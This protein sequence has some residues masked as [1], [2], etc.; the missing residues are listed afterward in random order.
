MADPDPVAVAY[1]RL[2]DFRGRSDPSTSPTRQRESVSAYAKARGWDLLTTIEDLDVSGSDV[3]L[4]LE[5]PG[6]RRVRDLLPKVDYVIIP[7][8]DRLA[9]NVVDFMTFAE[10]A[11][12]HD[13]ALVSVRESLDLGTPGGKFVAQILACFA[14]HEA[15]VIR[16]RVLAGNEAARRDGRFLGGTPPYGYESAPHPSG[17]GRTLILN[18]VEAAAI[19]DM[20]RRIL[21]DSWT[22][23]RIARD[24]NSRGVRSKTGK[25]W[26]ITSVRAVISG[27]ALVGMSTHKGKILT[28]ENGV[29]LRPYPSIVS[30]E[31]HR[32][33]R[34]L[35]AQDKKLTSGLRGPRATRLLS[36]L[37]VC[38]RC[39]ASMNVSPGGKGGTPSYRCSA[40]SR[41]WSTCSGVSIRSEALE[42]YVANEWLNLFGRMSVVSS[43]EMEEEPSEEELRTVGQSIADLA[44]AMTE[45]GADISALAIELESLKERRRLLKEGPRPRV[46]RESSRGLDFRRAWEAADDAETK[47]RLLTQVIDAVVV[48]PGVA[49]RKRFDPSRVSI[50]WAG[51]GRAI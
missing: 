2:S 14:E 15:A 11:A 6:L 46:L 33:V 43:V 51:E 22:P 16:G 4:R 28:D 34:A 13:V 48:A 37:V 44:T 42:Q 27:P 38:G 17:S 7:S 41:G 30:D 24:L 12:R 21:D 26:T 45:D 23:Y 18:E 29:A 39:G 31:D 3:G 9:R 49:G 20:Y 32:T 36:R 35:V 8:V 47:N 25:Q 19:R 10:E 5:R 1:V 40:A 50:R